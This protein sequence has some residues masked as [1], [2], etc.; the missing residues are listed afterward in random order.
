MRIGWSSPGN[1]AD[2]AA[3]QASGMPMGIGLHLLAHLLGRAQARR[4]SP[5]L[6]VCEHEE[7][8]QL[9]NHPADVSHQVVNHAHG[10][11]LPHDTPQQ[12]DFAGIRCHCVGWQEPADRSKDLQKSFVSRSSPSKVPNAQFWE[13]MLVSGDCHL[14]K[15]LAVSISSCHQLLYSNS[16][17]T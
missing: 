10:Q 2:T 3:Q 8:V 1:H 12:L 4:S 5:Y 6:L 7:F 17:C 11:I 13:C 14:M 9:L 15:K 16:M